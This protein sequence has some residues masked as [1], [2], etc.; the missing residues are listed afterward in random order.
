MRSA[1]DYLFQ[2]AAQ[3]LG[4]IV[5]EASL[6][7]DFECVTELLGDDFH[8]E[9]LRT[10]RFCEYSAGMVNTQSLCIAA[11]DGQFLDRNFLKRQ[12]FRVLRP[13]EPGPPAFR[14]PGR[15]VEADA[16]ARQTA[17]GQR[18]SIRR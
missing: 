2:V 4:P 14:K 9:L 6:H 12:I 5:V 16:E 10:A 8:G 7:L 1:A 3:M 11:A 15:R 13:A 17:T 18:Q